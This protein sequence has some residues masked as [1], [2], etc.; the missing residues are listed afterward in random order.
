MSENDRI[1]ETKQKKGFIPFVVLI[2]FLFD[3]IFL[4]DE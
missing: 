3:G 2:D 4:L 1:K